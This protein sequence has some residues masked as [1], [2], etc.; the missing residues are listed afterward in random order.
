MEPLPRRRFEVRLSRS[1]GMTTMRVRR[2]CHPT[3]LVTI[4]VMKLVASGS[5]RSASSSGAGLR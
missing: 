5:A 3:I 2:L 1:G 4:C